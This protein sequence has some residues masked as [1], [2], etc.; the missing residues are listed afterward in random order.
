MNKRKMGGKE[1]EE[2][3]GKKERGKQSGNEEIKSEPM[4]VLVKGSR[5]LDQSRGSGASG[6][7]KM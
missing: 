3:K 2:D 7:R 6:K 5:I 4:V 1:R